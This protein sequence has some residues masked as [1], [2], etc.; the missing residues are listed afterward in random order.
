[1]SVAVNVTGGNKLMALAVFMQA[2][3]SNVPAFYIDTDSDTLWQLGERSQQFPL[4]NIFKVK[5]Y[6]QAYGYC[7]L[8]AGG[9][10]VL[11]SLPP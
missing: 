9:K 4:P 3:S 6:L 1:M 2:W 8:A 11:L 10:S 7:V 5:L